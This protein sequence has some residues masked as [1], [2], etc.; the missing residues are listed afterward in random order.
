MTLR[1]PSKEGSL[2]CLL[3]PI[4]ISNPIDDPPAIG[5]LK[6]DHRMDRCG[7]GGRFRGHLVGGLAERHQ[8]EGVACSCPSMD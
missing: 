2:F 4:S 6:S 3:D 1:E 8:V 5:H 7:L